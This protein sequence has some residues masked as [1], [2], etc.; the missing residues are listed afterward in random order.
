MANAKKTQ[1]TATAQ[2]RQ[3]VAEAVLQGFLDSAL[4][5][6][7]STAR[8]AGFI[9]GQFPDADVVNAPIAGINR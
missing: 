3:Q 5:A 6:D 2:L 1:S 4:A 8:T 7:L 9:P